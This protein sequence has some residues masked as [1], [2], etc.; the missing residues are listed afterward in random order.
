MRAMPRIPAGRAALRAATATILALAALTGFGSTA[1]AADALTVTTP[2]PAIVVGPG[3]KVS[4][5]L[6][7]KTSLPA[8]VD[9]SLSGVPAKWTAAI[10]GGG[11]DISAV[12]TNG[13]DSTTAS[14]DLTVPADA[15][16]K[17]TITLTAQGNGATV[18]L[19]LDVNVNAT[20]AGD[21]TLTTDVPSQK[22]TSTT[23]FTFNL[24]IDN[25]TSQDL[26]FS[27]NAQGPDGWTTS[28][29]LT[30]SSQAASAIVKAGSTASV[31]ISTNPPDSVTSGTYPIDVTATAGAKQV[32][33][34][35]QVEITGSYTLTMSTPNQVLSNSG[36]AG[37]VTEQQLQLT[38]NGTAEVTNVNM[39]ATGP[40]NWKFDFDTKTVPSIPAGQS[41][42]VTA[43]VTPSGDAIAG[44]Y[45]LTF[46]AAGDNGS[47][48]TQAIRFTV[49]TSILG[50]LVGVA[51]VVLV[52]AG[53]WFVFQRYGRR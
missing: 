47:T 7:I 17:S 46:N 4:F 27:V 8:R 42:I 29:T 52:A 18:T 15:T 48:A 34:Q 51:I 35:L 2:Y 11:F 5:D 26:T 20:A 10:R 39:S 38:N 45:S 32:K 28:A 53:L 13:T 30:G 14:V 12:Q 25:S 21:V 22:G 40:T 16:G 49:Q 36:P 43:K 33:S 6:R 9:L 31:S 3:S 50:G 24:T 19:P 37:S 41:V 23:T 1:L 44:D